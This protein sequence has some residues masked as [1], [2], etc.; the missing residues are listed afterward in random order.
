MPNDPLSAHTPL[1]SLVPTGLSSIAQPVKVFATLYPES[2][3]VEW[4]Q[5][6]I[7][8]DPEFDEMNTYRIY[9][10]NYMGYT[11]VSDVDEY[12]GFRGEHLTHNGNTEDEHIALTG[13]NGVMLYEFEPFVIEP[14]VAAVADEGAVDEEAVDIA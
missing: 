8:D 1:S 13:E 6:Q 4:I 14:N 9:Q 2:D 10:Q 12:L 11:Y 5:E 3:T 7:A